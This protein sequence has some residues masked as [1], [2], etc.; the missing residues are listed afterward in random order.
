MKMMLIMT[1]TSSMIFT[2]IN[3]P[4]AMGLLLLLQTTMTSML[5]GLMYNSFWFSYILF[6]MFMGGMLVLFI[7]LTSIASNE[8][9]YMSK[10]II[11]MV[12]MMMIFFMMIKYNKLNMNNQETVSSMLIN[13]LSTKSLMKLYNSPTNMLMLMLVMYMFI[14]LI[15]V[16]KITNIYKGPLRKM[17]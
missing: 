16:V 5:T 10:K 8:M 11:I 12:I 2:Q 6:L 14:T 7:Y 9:F 13:N 1:T 4:M 15:M 3:H 17:S